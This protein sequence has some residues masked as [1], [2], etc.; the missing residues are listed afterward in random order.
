MLSFGLADIL[1]KTGASR[2]SLAALNSQEYGERRA[3]SPTL[4]RQAA[5]I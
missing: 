2:R 3:I 1:R 5:S 4:K